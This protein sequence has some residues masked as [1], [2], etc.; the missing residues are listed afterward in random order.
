[1]MMI[2]AE[3]LINRLN[4]IPH[5]EGGYYRETYRCP[6]SLP[7]TALAAGYDSARAAGT[8]IYYLLTESTCS[9]LHRLKS[10]E[11]YHF[12]LGDPVTMLHLYPDGTTREIVL[13]PNIV[14]GELPQV[15]IPRATWQGSFVLP[16]GRF[17]LL[18][19]TVSPGFDFADYETGERESL[20][21]QYP[22]QK[23]LIL[24]LT[25]GV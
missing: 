22:T 5:P 3:D 25:P 11:I 7:R 16:R 9:R 23:E 14:M 17:A 4:L 2:S 19:A 8:A 18:G 6:E 15:V 10:D 12:Y 24:R 21:R 1:M 20:L 13:G